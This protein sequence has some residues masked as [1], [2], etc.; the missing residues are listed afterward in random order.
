MKSDENS[1][2]LDDLILTGDYDIEY[3]DY[4]DESLLLD[5][6]RLVAADL[7]EPYSVF[8]YRYFLHTW[9]NLCICVY[10]TSSVQ[11]DTERVM[12]G[13][14]VSKAEYERDDNVLIGYIAMLAVNSQFRRRGIGQKVYPFIEYNQKK[15]YIHFNYFT[16]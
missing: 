2:I 5:I 9:P 15:F 8:T 10:A 11:K 14:I 12:I 7:S 4:T 1:K 6:Q 3:V 13:T 16:F